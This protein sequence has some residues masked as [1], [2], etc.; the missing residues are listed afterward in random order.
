MEWTA[1][2]IRDVGPTTV[3]LPPTETHPISGREILSESLMRSYEGLKQV[4][5]RAVNGVWMS[6]SLNGTARSVRAERER[7][8]GIGIWTENERLLQLKCGVRIGGRGN[9]QTQ[10]LMRRANNSSSFSHLVG[11]TLYQDNMKKG[12]VLLSNI[13]RSLFQVSIVLGE[14][15]EG[16][17]ILV[18]NE[19]IALYMVHATC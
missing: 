2:M 7:L 19:K 17:C 14:G 12:R 1:W 16:L 10:V 5:G 18:C 8:R 13:L 11:V 15:E 9:E 4:T 3:H 6:R